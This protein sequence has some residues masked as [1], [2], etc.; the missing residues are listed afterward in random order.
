MDARLGKQ[1]E[2]LLEYIEDFFSLSTDADGPGS[3][4]AVERSLKNGLLACDQKECLPSRL[5]SPSPFAWLLAQDYGV[6][7]HRNPGTYWLRNDGGSKY[8]SAARRF[9]ALVFQEPPRITLNPPVRG[10]VG[11]SDGLCL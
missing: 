8:R 1:E 3:F 10:P 7:A 11:P 9:R 2:Y 4:T 6:L 5:V